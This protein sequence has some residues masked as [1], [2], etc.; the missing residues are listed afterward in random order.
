MDDIVKLPENLQDTLLDEF[1]RLTCNFCNG[2]TKEE[3]VSSKKMYEN[4]FN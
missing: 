2:A 3:A 1:T 4:D